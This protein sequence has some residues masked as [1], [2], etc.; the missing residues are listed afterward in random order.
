MVESKFSNAKDAYMNEAIVKH[1][2]LQLLMF[3]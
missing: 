1:L 3:F 2:H